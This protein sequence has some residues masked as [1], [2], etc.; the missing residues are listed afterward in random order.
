[1]FDSVMMR[2]NTHQEETGMFYVGIPTTISAFGA[3]SIKVD[4]FFSLVMGGHIHNKTLSCRTAEG[5]EDSGHYLA[6]EDYNSGC[7]RILYI[8]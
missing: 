6:K 4:Y 8:S 3:I 1:M 2:C 5:W 7:I